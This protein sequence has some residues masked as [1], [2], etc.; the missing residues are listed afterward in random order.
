MKFPSEICLLFLQSFD[1][2]SELKSIMTCPKE[3]YNVLQ[4][5]LHSA[6]LIL[7]KNFEEIQDPM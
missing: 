4:N 5:H 3:S 6:V 7:E 1:L 2:G